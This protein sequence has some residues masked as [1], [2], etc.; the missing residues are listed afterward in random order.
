VRI[1]QLHQLLDLLGADIQGQ[2]DAGVGAGRR[3]LG[4]EGNPVVGGGDRSVP[5]SG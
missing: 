1:E 2:T 4:E 5:Y 3:I